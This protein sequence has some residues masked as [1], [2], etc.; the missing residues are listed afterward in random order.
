MIYKIK[1]NLNT[2]K[3]K[4]PQISN[5]QSNKQ[6]QIRTKLENILFFSILQVI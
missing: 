2:N 4:S 6:E 5:P 3:L 1:K